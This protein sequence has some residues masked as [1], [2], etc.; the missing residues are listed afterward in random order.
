MANSLENSEAGLRGAG[1]AQIGSARAVVAV[2]RTA[3]RRHAGATVLARSA[4]LG[5][6]CAGVAE[7]A[8]LVG[9]IAVAQGNFPAVVAATGGVGFLAGVT[10]FGLQALG[11]APGE[12]DL[13][14]GLDGRLGLK[15]RLSTA[16]EAAGWPAARG[17]VEAMLRAA[18]FADADTAA[19]A[20][21]PSE[22]ATRHSWRWAW[23]LPV[24]FGAVLALGAVHQMREIVPVAVSAPAPVTQEEREATAEV[25]R[26]IADLLGK[27][28]ETAVNAPVL[29]A[30]ARTV[31]AV[32]NDLA[33]TELSREEL[34]QTLT[35]LAQ[36]A[37]AGVGGATGRQIEATLGKQ[38]GALERGPLAAPSAAPTKSES[39]GAGN[40][41]APSSNG[42]PSKPL[43]TSEAA[44]TSLQP[45]Q[46]PPKG[47]QYYDADQYAASRKLAEQGQNQPMNGG[48]PAG[49][50]EHSERGGNQ[51]GDGVRPLVASMDELAAA[52]AAALE[53]MILPENDASAGQRVRINTMPPEASAGMD[54]DGTAKS[55]GWRAGEIEPFNRES[56]LAGSL[57]ILK[58]YFP[59]AGGE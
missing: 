53:T 52:N 19:R 21:M 16:I 13:A 42:K 12:L 48:T 34:T 40:G 58:R 51:A 29:D 30:L 26:E 45:N 54:V 5:L 8:A 47:G 3:W 25:L 6:A 4:A 55:D 9:V 39:G 44:Q 2:A 11:R 49:A 18:L 33:T 15:E 27:D 36:Q 17:G 10:G 20:V 28:K 31:E 43:P 24:L 41:A 57:E 22:V 46:T 14:R 50:A 23:A 37:A 35:D 38:I 32:R 1:D 56:G 59:Q 7:V